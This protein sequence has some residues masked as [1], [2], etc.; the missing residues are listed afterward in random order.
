M[1]LYSLLAADYEGAGLLPH[2]L[3]HYIKLGIK[4][5]HMLL[6]VNHNPS[7]TDVPHGSLAT[8]TRILDS[9]G[10]DYTHWL[11][12]YSADAHLKLKLQVLQRAPVQ[13]WI[14]IVDSDEF[15][16]FGTRTAAEFL[17]QADAQGANWV[18]GLFVDRVSLNGSLTAI[19]PRPSIWEQYPLS[20]DI[21]WRLAHAEPLKVAAFKGYLRSGV[22]NHGIIPPPMA[23][24]YFGPAKPGEESARYG[25]CGA[26]DLYPYTPYY[27]Y[28]H[29]YRM[30]ARQPNPHLWDI[31]EANTT[32][33]VH[34]FKWHRGVERSVRDR[35]AHYRG[36]DEQCVAGQPRFKFWRESER[37]MKAITSRGAVDVTSLQLKCHRVDATHK[38]KGKPAQQSKP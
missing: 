15:H 2:F 25:L 21:A 16:D 34:H 38:F 33:K 9:Y 32:I 19:K 24:I 7:H 35:L 26:E 30:S 1:W 22:G 31:V 18:K 11:G 10:I 37:L 6:I 27:T 23:K 4:R 8:L 29:L 28:H 36:D 20:C 17:Q 13:D 5:D 14:I 12:Q 3:D